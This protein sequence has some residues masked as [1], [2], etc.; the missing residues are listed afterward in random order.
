MNIAVIGGGINGLCIAWT[1]A[2]R[3][4]EIELFEKGKL[5][6]GTSSTSTKLLHGGLRYLEQGQFRLV[7]EAL[8]QR[9][10]WLS[11]VPE[12][13]RKLEIILPVYKTAKRSRWKIKIGL[14]LYDRLS[15]KYSI[16]EHRWLSKVNLL[17]KY[18]AL[19][20]E[21]LLGGYRF[22]DG[23]MD[24]MNLGQW[25]AQQARQ[26]GAVLHTDSEVE[27]VTVDGKMT[28]R[29]A[30]SKQ[31]DFIVNATGPMA[32]WLLKK[33]NVSS[34]YQLKL[35]KGSHI[36]LSGDLSTGFMFEHPNDAR[37]IF[38]LPYDEQILIGTT[39]IAVQ[40]DDHIYCSQQEKEYLLTAHNYYFSSNLTLDEVADEF[41]GVRPLVETRQA[42]HTTSRENQLEQNM[43]LLTVWGGKWTTARSLSIDVANL[44]SEQEF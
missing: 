20:P 7:R 32:E 17:Q 14:G 35:V 1:L 30:A 2:T 16:G 6:H 44:I 11:N 34:D 41:S 15:G 23:Q 12:Y 40:L 4:H 43:K 27:T 19:R 3:G 5:L 33:S 8:E 18:P 28:L 24:E 21:G 22:F 10:W 31:F 36:M 29:D 42:M 9:H 39:E 25:V 26:S 38:I 13:T 37:P